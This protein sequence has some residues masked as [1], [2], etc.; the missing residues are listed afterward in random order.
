MD[1]LFNQSFK[2]QEANFRIISVFR[3]HIDEPLSCDSPPWLVLSV[4]PLQ[5]CVLLAELCP[6]A[7]ATNSI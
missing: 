5:S 2:L 6:K 4:A 1:T 3:A 7:L